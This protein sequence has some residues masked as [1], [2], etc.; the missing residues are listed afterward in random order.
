VL[1][2]AA[3]LQLPLI[4]L[5]T[6]SLFVLRAPGTG[7]GF[8]AGLSFALVLTLH[9]LVF[10]AEA[11]RKTPPGPAGRAAVG[12][13][14]IGVLVATGAPRLAFGHEIVEASLF[15]LTFGAVSLAIG[16]IVGRAP[17]MRDEDW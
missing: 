10:G 7:V 14:M 6:A 3:R 1:R 2:A 12:F 13:G 11:A 4:A 8:L 17:T 16:V 5:F 15:L 9:L